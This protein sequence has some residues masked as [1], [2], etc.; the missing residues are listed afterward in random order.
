[1]Y[2][3]KFLNYLPIILGLLTIITAFYTANEKLS[4][5]YPILLL[6]LTLI[7]RGISN[8]Y[9]DKIT[10]LNKKDKVM[11]ENLTYDELMN[12]GLIEKD[13]DSYTGSISIEVDGNV[14]YTYK[15][16]LSN[17]QY[18]INGITPDVTSGDVEAS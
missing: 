10:N 3:A 14:K 8:A 12:S 18:M 15:I 6:I 13:D 5:G 17:G 7:V 9:I 1:M 11:L 16:W 2:K 4:P